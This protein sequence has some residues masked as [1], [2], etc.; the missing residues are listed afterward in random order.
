MTMDWTTLN[1]PGSD[2]Y[3]GVLVFHSNLYDKNKKSE[4]SKWFCGTIENI[5]YITLSKEQTEKA[6]SSER[7]QEPDQQ[8]SKRVCFSVGFPLHNIWRTQS[9]SLL[10][11]IIP[12]AYIFF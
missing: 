1:F 11:N 3:K 8:Q 12:Q 9:F 10:L 6:H 7:T 4:N 5:Q 2:M